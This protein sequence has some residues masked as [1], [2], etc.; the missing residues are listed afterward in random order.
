MNKE[1][2]FV[3]ATRIAQEAR[4]AVLDTLAKI[5]GRPLTPG[6]IGADGHVITEEEFK[7]MCDAIDRA[8]LHAILGEN[9]S[10]LQG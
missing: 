10:S 8:G 6:S 2:E 5:M 7:E 9:N 3:E 1:I 4:W